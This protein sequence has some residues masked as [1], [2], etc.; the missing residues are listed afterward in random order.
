[1]F[2]VKSI[3]EL[4]HDTDMNSVGTPPWLSTFFLA[5]PPWNLTIYSWNIIHYILNDTQIEQLVLVTAVHENHP[6][7]SIKDPSLPIYLP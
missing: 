1:M 4:V 7:L 3:A 5:L 2:T 6:W